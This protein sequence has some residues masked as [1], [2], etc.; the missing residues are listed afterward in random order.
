VGAL[1]GTLSACTIGISDLFGRRLVRASSPLTGAVAISAVAAVMSLVAVGLFGSTLLASDFALGAASGIGLGVGLAS[2]Y[3][4]MT[5]SSSTVVTPVVAALSAI[6]PFAYAV[7][8]GQDA[9]LYALLGAVI[10][11][12]GL[13]LITVGGGGVHHVRAGLIWGAIS[14]LAYGTGFAVVIEASDGAGAL[15]ALGQRIA[16][17]VVTVA[18]ALRQGARLVAPLHVRRSALIGGTLAGLSTVLYL[19]GVR[20]DATAAV[21]TTSMFPA[22]TVAVGRTAFGDPVSRLQAVGIAVALGGIV[23]VV[24]G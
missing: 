9:S 17:T 16:A 22:V 14:G 23:L 3:A 20:A 21:I 2:Y 4:G 18:L 7:I 8:A 13:V 24:T 1:F 6:I 19:A 10:A 5:R 15:P 12:G 11:V